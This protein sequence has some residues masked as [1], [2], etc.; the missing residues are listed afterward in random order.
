MFASFKERVKKDKGLL[1]FP[2]GICNILRFPVLFADVGIA[3]R[4]E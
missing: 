3:L 1:P 4:R 2:P